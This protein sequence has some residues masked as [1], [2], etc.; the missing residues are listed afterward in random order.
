VTPVIKYSP[1]DGVGLILTTPGEKDK[2]ESKHAKFYNELWFAVLMVVLSLIFLAILLSLILQRK[3]HKQ[4][5]A[6]DRPPL[7]PLQKRTSPMS[8]YS[9]GETH[10]FE[11]IADT[12]DS[13]SSVTLKRYTTH[14]EGL[15]DT[16]IPGGSPTSNRSVHI[17]SGARR[18]GQS[19]LSRTYSQASLHRSVSQLL[20]LYDKK[21]FVDDPPWD[22]IIRNHR[23]AGRGLY[24]DEE[25]LVNVIKGFSTVTK[26]HTT[27][28]DTHL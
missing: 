6:R 14:Y 2:A 8:V 27:F 11:T 26:E 9:T 24:V 7:V 22:A 17:A 5:Y 3:V 10:P 18:A 23:A 4:P 1:G 28:T 13:S 12:S 16:K 25:D 20:D 19:P 15:E 21:S